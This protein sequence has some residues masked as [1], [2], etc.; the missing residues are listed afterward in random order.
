MR[1]SRLEAWLL[2][3]GA[4]G[5]LTAVGGV[6]FFASLLPFGRL[7]PWGVGFLGILM[8]IAGVFG[9]VAYIVS[10]LRAVPEAERWVIEVFGS[11]SHIAQPGLTIL[12]TGIEK[13]R[14]RQ[15]TK[16][17]FVSVDTTGTFSLDDIKI[18]FSAELYYQLNGADL[19]AAYRATYAYERD[20]KNPEQAIKNL[21]EAALRSIAG[22]KNRDEMK[23]DQVGLNL[24][25]LEAIGKKMLSWGFVATEHVIKELVLLKEIRD[26]IQ[27]EHI[28]KA[29]GEATVATATAQSKATVLAAN[30]EAEKIERLANADR[31]KQEQ[32]GIGQ[33]ALL[34]ATGAVMKEPGVAE[35]KAFDLSEKAIASLGQARA[36]VVPT[37]LFSNIL[38]SATGALRATDTVKK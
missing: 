31:V 10:G 17:Q 25:I 6:L 14:S 37:D 12:L 15:T 34:K 11:F 33:A 4:F 7:V 30:A 13:V 1:I 23:N 16:E 38:A 35:S 21:A 26:A 8:V 32:D 19:E 18:D 3:L 28:A 36:I 22:T 9:G 27:K 29:E 2:V 20:E 24:L 5:F